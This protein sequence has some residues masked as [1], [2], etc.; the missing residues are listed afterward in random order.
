MVDFMKIIN[1]FF[2][3]EWYGRVILLILLIA[4]A[5]SIVP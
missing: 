1:E 4:N 2:W 3:S 5:I